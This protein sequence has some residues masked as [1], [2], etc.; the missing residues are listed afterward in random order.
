M[1]V[2]V[3][4]AG[5]YVTGR[6]GTGTGTVLSSLAET[7]KTV[8]IDQVVVAARHRTNRSVVA[9]AV[10]RI[11]KTIGSDLKVGYEAIEGNAEKGIRVL[12]RKARFDC[13]IVSVPD[14]LHFSYAH[15]ILKRG[16]HCLVVKPLVPTLAEAKKLVR[17]QERM[18]LH[19]AVEFHKRFDE[20]NLFI[21]K[22]LAEKKIGKLL[23]ITVDYSQKIT[24]P[25]KVFRGWADKTN[26]FQYLGVH[27]VDLIYFLTGYR[28]IKAM[29]VGT[30]GILKRKGVD[31]YDSV[32]AMI[33]WANPADPKDWFLSQFSTNW[34]DPACT[35]AMSDQKY[36][37]VGTVGRIECDQKNRGV[38]LVCEG[39]GV[40]A[41]NPYFSEVLPGP[42]GALRFVGYGHES[43]DLFIRDVRDLKVGKVTAGSLEVHRPTF[44][45]SMVS[46]AVIEAVNR[47]L[48][49]NS[50][51]VN[52]H[53]AF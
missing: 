36:K 21:K 46:T 15:E 25:L 3:V 37:I 13:A 6:G 14:H 53:A 7:S 48:S 27:Y 50:R 52:I 2:L 29:A 42:D 4:G 41:V 20:T 12:C 33:T 28:A 38:E 8:K 23:Y 44:R 40:Q 1:R 9:D 17:E 10:A 22:A 31:T 24:I 5:M 19:G 39:Q 11:N 45:Q 26:I 49:G 47:S 16:M 35:S 18:G 30:D 43:I 51:W 32:H 34:V